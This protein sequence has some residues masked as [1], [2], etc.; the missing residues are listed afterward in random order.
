MMNSLKRQDRID[1]D[2]LIGAFTWFEN[3]PANPHSASINSKQLSSITNAAVVEAKKLELPG[4]E[5]RLRTAIARLGGESL[6]QRFRRLISHLRDRFG[7]DIVSDQLE[8]DCKLAVSLRGKA[9]HA[10]LADD[11]NSFIDLAKAIYAVEYV[12]FLL[13][14][15]D[16]PLSAASISRLRHHP[17]LEYF[18]FEDPRESR[19]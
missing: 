17:F 1:K 16:L 3:I 7:R 5:D 11:E 14:I 13:M 12:S 6:I 8:G 2:R 10:S 18:R 4:I 15:Y 19:T 9:A